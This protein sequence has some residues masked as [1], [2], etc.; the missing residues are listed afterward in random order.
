MT[1]VAVVLLEVAG[2]LGMGTA[3][4]RLLKIDDD[5]SAGEC[6]AFAFVIGFG[7][8]GWLVFPLGII[9]LLQK[10]W[11]F[12]LLIAATSGMVFWRKGI[13]RLIGSPD[14]VAW[15]LLFLIAAVMVLDLAEGLSPPGDADSLAYHFN[16]PRLFLE[17]GRINFILRPLDGAIPYLTQMTYV[18]ALGLGGEKA[19]T[20]W[21]MVS[22]WAAAA[23][24]FVLCRRHLNL[25]WSLAVSLVFMTVPT[26]VYAAGTG[27]IEIRTAMFVMVA[28]WATARALETGRLNY[29]LLA[30]LA[31]GFYGGSK[32]IGL[33]F[34]LACGLII[35][36]QRRWLVHGLALT[37]VAFV[38]GSQWYIWNALHTGDPFFPM[39]FQ[40]LGRDDLLLWN[41]A[42]DIYFKNTFFAFDMA[43]PRTFYW[44]LTYP[45]SATLDPSPTIES[46]RTGFGP[47][48]L[49]LLPFAVIGAWKFRD[50]I[51]NSPLLVYGGL[52]FLFY[53]FW[54]FSG[55]SQRVR[56]LLPVLPL[57]IICFSVAAER[58]AAAR[59]TR[60]PLIAA[61]TA[62][63][64]L[65]LGGQVLFSLKYL[66]YLSSGEDRETFLKENIKNYAPV[67][68]I[69]AN[70]SKSDKLLISERQLFYFL[71]VP[72]LFGSPHTQAV[73][74]LRTGQDD[75]YILYRQL[76]AAGIT[77]LMINPVAGRKNT[78]YAKPFESLNKI[79]CFEFM[80]RFNA[81]SVT[82]RTLPGILS[83]TTSFDLV[84]LKP[85]KC[86]G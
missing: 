55:A 53:T 9:G 62:T 52:A 41:K 64:I 36:V 58:F 37:I 63:I 56:H 71:R 39:L 45:F 65:Q 46:G 17:A 80:R 35:L 49:A 67:P 50:R 81:D 85:A 74:D 73:I 79:G 42:Q 18:P 14:A 44:F 27:Q 1:A 86:L 61:I 23:M 68:W 75:P 5:F 77:H 57:L 16:A 54:F 30:G 29:A 12:G 69:N 72:Y 76:K 2:C 13:P 24:L 3:M 59:G 38:A 22:G 6:L 60:T 82:S 20:L 26:V 78:E 4:L 34:A 8:L 32:Y 31:V 66:K 51:R 10:P 28:A 70:L 25:N 7:L 15:C 83:S 33:L 47:F 40:W 19:L 11:L 43:A 21:T 48:G 84:K